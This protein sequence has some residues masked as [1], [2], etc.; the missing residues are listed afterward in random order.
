MVLPKPIATVAS[1]G[2]QS[3]ASPGGNA[4]PTAPISTKMDAI[5]LTGDLQLHP[6]LGE[7]ALAV[8][9]LDDGSL[10]IAGVIDDATGYIVFSQFI[11]QVIESTDFSIVNNVSRS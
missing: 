8:K 7:Y 2:E 1:V 6:V 4:V 5:E 11:E 3:I 9:S 10:S